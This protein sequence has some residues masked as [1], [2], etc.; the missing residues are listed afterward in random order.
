MTRRS[1]LRPALALLAIAFSLATASPAAAD[2][3]LELR[4]QLGGFEVEGYREEAR[5]VDV[6]LWFAEEALVREDD[7]SRIVL[8]K[9]QLML[10]NHEAETYSLVPLP[11]DLEKLVDEEDRPTLGRLRELSQI[12]AEVTAT[13]ERRKIGQWN[14][15]RHDVLLTS[16]MGQ[17]IAMEIWLSTEV[18][19]PV[20]RFHRLMTTLASLQPGSQEVAAK[21]AAL[22]GF[23]VL[24]VT[25][26]RVLGQE[27]TTRDELLRVEEKDTPEGLF[28]PP[29]GYEK[30]PF[31]PLP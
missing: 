20:K 25:R 14:A 9:D 3:L 16:A 11:V 7:G 18:E 4:T 24:T 30:E 13:E 6:K 28:T 1:R 22:E 12:E 8:T 27:V 26:R 17:E 29:E 15:R 21:L 2:T 10:V 31:D 23:P 19:V 5:D